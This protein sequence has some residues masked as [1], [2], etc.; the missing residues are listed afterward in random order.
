MTY[1]KETEKC[2]KFEEEKK[3]THEESTVIESNE[4]PKIVSRQCGKKNYFGIESRISDGDT[5]QYG[6]FYVG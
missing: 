5:A 1:C 4:I 6:K 3:D 2:C